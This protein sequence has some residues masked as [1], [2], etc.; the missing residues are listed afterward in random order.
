ME[1]LV[2]PPQRTKAI[3]LVLRKPT[4]LTFGRFT[5][6]LNFYCLRKWL[7]LTLQFFCFFQGIARISWSTKKQLRSSGTTRGLSL[8]KCSSR[9]SCSNRARKRPAS[10]HMEFEWHWSW[11]FVWSRRIRSCYVSVRRRHTERSSHTNGTSRNCDTTQEKGTYC[12]TKE[13]RV[14]IAFL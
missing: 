1:S 14:L 5:F 3:H 8:N 4:K 10:S 12:A 7:S 2:N 6:D 13:S 9:C 11:R